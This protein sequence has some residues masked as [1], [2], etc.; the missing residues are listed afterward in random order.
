MET[1]FATKGGSRFHKTTICESVERARLIYDSDE[2]GTRSHG[3]E[4]TTL[5]TAVGRGQEACAT[6]FPGLRPAWYRSSEDDFGHEPF[7]Y[8]GVTICTRCYVIEVRCSLDAFEFPHRV[9]TR[10]PVAWPCTSAI[11]LGLVPREVTA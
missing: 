2:F 7:G 3:W 6:C 10:Q 4:S 5:A 9:V 11:V 1:V 8:D